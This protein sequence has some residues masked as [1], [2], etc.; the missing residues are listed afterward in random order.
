MPCFI[1]GAHVSTLSREAFHRLAATTSRIQLRFLQVLRTFAIWL[2]AWTFVGL[3]FVG[4][5]ATQKFFMGD[6]TLWKEV[7]F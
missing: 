5:N 4:Q 7:G 6:P 2:A 3:I 1:G